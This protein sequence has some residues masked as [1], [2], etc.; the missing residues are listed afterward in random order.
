MSEVHQAD[1]STD[2]LVTKGA[3]KNQWDREA[4]AISRNSQGTLGHLF[5]AHGPK[6]AENHKPCELLRGVQNRGPQIETDRGSGGCA[7]QKN[8]NS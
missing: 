5:A 8:C 6:G 4:F 1:R 3:K 7:I 2:H